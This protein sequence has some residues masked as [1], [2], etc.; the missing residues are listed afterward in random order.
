M[1]IPFRDDEPSK[2]DIIPPFSFPDLMGR[3][4]ED[5][6]RY[7]KSTSKFAEWRTQEAIEWYIRKKNPMRR[8]AQI[9]RFS[10]IVFAT[11]G[12]L[13]PFISTSQ[14]IPATKFNWQEVGYIS[15][16]IA[17]FCIGLDKYFG[18]SSSWVRFIMTSI[19]LQKRLAKF[20]YDW[21]ILNSNAADH[22]CDST[23]CEKMLQSI[24]TFMLEVLS[25]LEKEA[26]EWAVQYSNNIA[27]MEKAAQEQFDATRSGK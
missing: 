11:F 10:A 14:L 22:Q 5:R 26:K 24:Q 21:A 16:G 27:D 20:Q 12:V 23:T 13:I 18:F 9:L 3:S 25:E 19:A 4:E 6:R 15:L 17:V 1:K 7:L 8:N 2:K